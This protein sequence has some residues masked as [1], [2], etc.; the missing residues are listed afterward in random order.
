M[1]HLELTAKSYEVDDGAKWSIVDIHYNGEY[2]TKNTISIMLNIFQW[3][4][5]SSWAY[6]LVQDDD[7]FIERNISSFILIVFFVKHDQVFQVI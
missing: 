3:I 6:R 1:Y 5:A 2:I 4:K 7:A